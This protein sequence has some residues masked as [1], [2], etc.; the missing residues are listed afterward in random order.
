MQ[1][2]GQLVQNKNLHTD[3]HG[4]GPFTC[5]FCQ[6]VFPSWNGLTL[7]LARCQKRSHDRVFE[8]GRYRFVVHMNPLRKYV[9]ALINFSK[10]PNIDDRAF[11]SGLLLLKECGHIHD[12][13]IE[14]LTNVDAPAAIP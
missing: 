10:N 6:A 14:R 9:R 12:F 8:L 3:N 4:P 5:V 1:E 2:A 13:D 7:H 11:A